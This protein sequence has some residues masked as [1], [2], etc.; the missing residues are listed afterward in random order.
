LIYK[1]NSIKKRFPEGN[2]LIYEESYTLLTIMSREKKSQVDDMTK[3]RRILDNSSD[4][5]LK[6]LITKDEVALESVRRRLSGELFMTYP[7]TDRFFRASESMEPRVTIYTKTPVSPRLVLPPPQLKPSLPLPE[8][9]FVSPT[10]PIL[11][12]PQ[13]QSN[14]VDE[15][16]FEV[17]KIDR[18]IPEFLEV[19]PRETTQIFPEKDFTIRDEQTSLQESRLPEWQPVEGEPVTESPKILEEQTREDIP[20]FERVEITST[21]DEEPADEWQTSLKTKEQIVPSV[22]VLPTESP[23]SSFENLTKKQQRAAK[24]AQKKKEK[25]EK[26]Q[27][28]IELKRLKKEQECVATQTTEEQ[29]SFSKPLEDAA[30]E[31]EFI[32]ETE[33]SQI[34]VDYNNFKGIE[35]IDEKTAE[36]LYKNG[37]FSIENIKDATLD[38]LVQIRGIRR[39]LAKQMKKEIDQHIAET[40]T[41]EFIPAKGHIPKKKEKKQLPD[42]A[43][44]ESSP[45]KE[46]LQKPLSSQICTYKRYTLYTK[47]IRKQDG[48]R[49]TIHFFAKT[50]PD[51]GHPAHLP[52]G[53]RI[54]LNKKTGV[55]YLKK[56]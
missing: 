24:K 36:L 19:I 44:W 46:K 56:K 2:L 4:P 34:S 35:C 42:S 32:K 14:F 33:L 27:R 26:K 53:Y 5:S 9:E 52:E 11:S 38:D 21:S 16:L 7:K 40:A 6:N 30:A 51:K 20:E 41:S 22:D 8:F 15:E 54:A 1:E 31:E 29:P 50:V 17:E 28:K 49:S 43:E 18:S 25:E 12:R 3:L 47:E 23:D 45:S 48:K 10:S 13:E 55:P 37:Y 39:K